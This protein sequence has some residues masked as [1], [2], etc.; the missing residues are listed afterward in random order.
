MTAEHSETK[1]MTETREWKT[2]T[3]TKKYGTETEN[4]VINSIVYV[5]VKH[6]GIGA[7][8]IKSGTNDYVGEGNPHAEFGN[9]EITGGLSPHR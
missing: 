1:A 5:K 8:K 3:E 4:N 6:I 2:K 9:I 7:I